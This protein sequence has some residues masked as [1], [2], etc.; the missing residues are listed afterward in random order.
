MCAGKN[1]PE[2]SVDKLKTAFKN[3]TSLKILDVRTPAELKE[4]LG[5]IEGVI[6]SQFKNWKA[7]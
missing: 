1:I 6:N 5:K 2:M 4:P 3:D 7:E